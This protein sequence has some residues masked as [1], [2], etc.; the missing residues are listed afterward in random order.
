MMV[1]SVISILMIV[2]AMLTMRWWWKISIQSRS[3]SQTLNSWSFVSIHGNVWSSLQLH[4]IGLFWVTLSFEN[5]HWRK[6]WTNDGRY[7]SPTLIAD[8]EFCGDSWSCVSIHGTIWSTLN[9]PAMSN[10]LILKSTV[11]KSKTNA[12]TEDIQSRLWI[13]WSF[14]KLRLNPIGAIWLTLTWPVSNFI[15][16]R[17]TR[18]LFD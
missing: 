4:W 16:G 18:K 9:W 6:S 2:Y 13:L 5:A 1:W 14:L 10:F 11:E 7:P 15:V 3:L 17:I 8:S 12:M